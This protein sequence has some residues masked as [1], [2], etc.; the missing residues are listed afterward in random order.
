MDDKSYY[1][2]IESILRQILQPIEKISFSTFIRV[3]SGYPY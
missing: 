1:E 2:E 3:V